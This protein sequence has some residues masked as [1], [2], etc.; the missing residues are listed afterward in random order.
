M[1]RIWRAPCAR[2]AFWRGLLI[3]ALSIAA[4]SNEPEKKP[5]D[6]Q[7]AVMGYSK[8]QLIACAGN[9]ATD[10]GA[11]G[12]EYLV[13]HTEIVANEG[14]LQGIPRIP[15]IGSLATGSKGD[16]FAC[17]A[18]FILK[19]GLVTASSL[20]IDPPQDSKTASQICAPVVARCASP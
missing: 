18:T 6:P 16:K 4:C 19:G 14:Y 5:P 13:Y 3:L 8:A 7:F 1:I 15:V 12:L 10:T 11:G 2:Q 9:P 17:E 20:R